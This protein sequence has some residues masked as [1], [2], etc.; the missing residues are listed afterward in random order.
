MN[1]MDCIEQVSIPV[2]SDTDV[3][4]KGDKEDKYG[5]PNV[6]PMRKDKLRILAP[7]HGLVV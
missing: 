5:K 1:S 2:D 7:T 3:V 6:S 4:V